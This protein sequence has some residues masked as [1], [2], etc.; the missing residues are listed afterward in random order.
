MDLNQD[1]ELNQ[2]IDSSI[3]ESVRAGD[4]HCD[5]EN[6]PDSLYRVRATWE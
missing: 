1:M 5:S 2:E 6:N 3:Y 4:T